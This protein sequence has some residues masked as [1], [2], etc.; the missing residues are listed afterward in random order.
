MID[1]CSR[2]E[3]LVRVI[4]PIST[5]G[6]AAATVFTTIYG[7]SQFIVPFILLSNPRLLPVSVGILGYQSQQGEITLHYV[8]AASI[9]AMLPAVLLFAVLQRFIVEVLTDGAVKG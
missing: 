9:I 7:W 6:I 1:G 2:V 3:A 8:A 5:P 4:L